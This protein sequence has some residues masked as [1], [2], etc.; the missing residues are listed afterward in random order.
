M[1]ISRMGLK[2]VATI[3]ETCSPIRPT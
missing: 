3:T 2:M 1:H